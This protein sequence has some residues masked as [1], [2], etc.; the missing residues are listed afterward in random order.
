MLCFVRQGTAGIMAKKITG[1]GLRFFY[2]SEIVLSGQKN[3]SGIPVVLSACEVFSVSGPLPKRKRIYV[4][5]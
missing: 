4:P 5:D 1:P 3:F 2:Y